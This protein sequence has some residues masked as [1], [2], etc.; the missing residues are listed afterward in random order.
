MKICTK[1]YIEKSTFSFSKDKNRTDGRY[2]QCIDCRKIHYKQDK[3]KYP[4][5]RF[6]KLIKQRCNDFNKDNYKYYGLRG[7][8]CLITFEQLKNLWYRDKA[9]LLKKPSID[10][11]NNNKN[12]TFNNCQ[13][14][15]HK[16]N[17]VKRDMSKIIKSIRQYDLNRNF[18]KE[19]DTITIASKKLNIDNSTIVKCAKNKRKTAGGYIWKYKEF[20]NA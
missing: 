5:K 4:W 15:E 11:K 9:Y 13:F 10:R 16:E 7:I 17:S 14:I 2:P 20:S 19:Y 12:Y 6:L 18:I 8:K 3:E 1:C